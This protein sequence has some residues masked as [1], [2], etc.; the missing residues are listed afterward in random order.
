MLF[1][2]KG[3]S[4]VLTYALDNNHNFCYL[5]IVLVRGVLSAKL[6]LSYKDKFEAILY[7]LSQNSVPT[8]CFFIVLVN[9]RFLG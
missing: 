1:G 5:M 2:K 3:N 9:L 7:G 4:K 6:I 8:S